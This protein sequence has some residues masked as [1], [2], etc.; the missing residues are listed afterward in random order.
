MQAVAGPG[1][2]E[3]VALSRG[4]DR[5]C[6]RAARGPVR[7]GGL[8]G[9]ALCRGESRDG[10]GR[11]ADRAV[12]RVRGVGGAVDGLG[13]GLDVLLAGLVVEVLEPPFWRC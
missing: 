1:A 2:R 13:N 7:R 11:V 4:R 3:A 12:E 10:G 8:V 9:G 6:N 5:S